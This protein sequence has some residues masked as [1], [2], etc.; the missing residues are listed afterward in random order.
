LKW[1]GLPLH[2]SSYALLEQGQR[3]VDIGELIVLAAYLADGD[4]QALLAGRATERV[5][6][7]QLELR[8]E[9]V[10]DSLAGTGEPAED[11]AVAF[12]GSDIHAPGEAEQKAARRL[13]VSAADVIDAAVWLWGDTLTNKRDRL[14]AERVDETKTDRRT[15][16]AVRGGVTRKLV[17]ELAEYLANRE[18]QR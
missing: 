13:Q 7:Y 8:L 17:A 15:L 18:E 1:L 14:V 5:E 4:V 16:Q 2:R 9:Q 3:N 10:R 11:E 12:L 6:L